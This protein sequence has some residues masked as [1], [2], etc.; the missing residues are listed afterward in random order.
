MDPSTDSTVLP[1]NGGAEA[2]GA[3]KSRWK[4]YAGLGCGCL[5]LLL[6]LLAGGGAA[7]YVMR[8]DGAAPWAG[9][10]DGVGQADPGQSDP[11]QVDDPT[12]QSIEEQI[13]NLKVGES[14]SFKV[15]IPPGEAKTQQTPPSAKRQVRAKKAAEAFLGLLEK[16]RMAQAWKMT[17]QDLRQ[18]MGNM[19]AFQA[20]ENVQKP[21]EIAPGAS[22]TL[23]EQ[24]Y[25]ISHG[26][27]GRPVG[28]QSLSYMYRSRSGQD[29]VLCVV[30][31]VDSQ[32]APKVH[33]A[34][35]SDDFTVG[36]LFCIPSRN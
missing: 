4:L 29:A 31:I 6:I 8:S 27:G 13:M 35:K 15:N 11:G 7:F 19:T 16:G 24:D 22:R 26:V 33:K 20:S 10:L 36:A 34:P 17:A 12:P 23:I 3:P 1:P 21:S 25:T 30:A 28:V 2:T 5:S 32:I 9:I 18:N 14:V